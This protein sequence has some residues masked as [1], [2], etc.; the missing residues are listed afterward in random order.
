[1]D[2]SAVDT[3]VL[4]PPVS[5][6]IDIEDRAESF[7]YLHRRLVNIVALAL[8]DALAIAMALLAAG[9][10]RWFLKGVDMLPAWSSLLIVMWW[11]GALATHLL[12]GWGLGSVETLRKQVALLSAVFGIAIVAIFLS[13]TSSLASRM[14]LTMGYLFGLV[15]VPVVRNQVRNWLLKSGRWGTPVVIYGS[16]RTVPLVMKA[17]REENSL[18]YDP[19]GLFD[20]ES[21][22]GTMIQGVPV[23]GGIKDQTHSAPV[24]IVAMPGISR[25][26]LIVLLD[27]PLRSYRT[28][29][30]IPDLIEAP[31]LWVQPR[32]LQGILGL[33][34]KSNLLNPFSQWL[35]RASELLLVLVTTPLWFPLSL[36]IALFIWLEDR[37]TPLYAQE[38]MGKDGHLFKMW[39]FRTMHMDAEDML[40]QKMEEQPE[41]RL[42]WK[43]NFKLKDDPRVTRTGAL[44]RR[45]SLDELPQLINVL[46]GEMS[47]VGPRPLPAYHY[48]E[49]PESVR[50]VRNRVRPGMTG[51]WQVTGRSEIGTEG[52]ERWDSYYVRNWSIWLDIVS[53]IRTVKAVSKRNGA[54]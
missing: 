4:S 26:Q 27:G 31:S 39:K 36:V 17:I 47:L 5:S 42:E 50:D 22:K 43:K 34:I 23:L 40:E 51:L 13:K 6:K 3:E 30:V 14:T 21:S 15:L 35:K 41:L 46:R 18:G 48:Y 8:G 9:S 1:M 54:Y 37:D 38:R 45:A 20:D 12:P 25:H 44:L 32:D 24:A 49:L 11:I 19:V 29:L 16:D 2:S 7:R 10:V 28:V 53:M 52:M 33:E